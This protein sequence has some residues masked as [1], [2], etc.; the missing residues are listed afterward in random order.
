MSKTLGS[1]A[2]GGGGGDVVT[3]SIGGGVSIPPNQLNITLTPPTGQRVRLTH[4]S[5]ETGE[6]VSGVKIT[7]GGSDVLVNKKL[8]GDAPA[9]PS[10]FSVGSFQAY[11]AGQPPS[12]NIQH[13]T[14]GVDEVMVILGATLSVSVYFSY[15]FGE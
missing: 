9:A 5:T 4:L 15:E 2:G 8:K 13:I 3:R 10:E 6:Q 14:G 11:T 1:I 7:I 12:G